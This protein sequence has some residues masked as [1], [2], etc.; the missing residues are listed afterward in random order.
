M[1][2]T[3]DLLCVS[4]HQ[5][6]EFWPYAE[7]L[8]KTA[9]DRC[10]E[11]SVAEIKGQINKGALL[12][13][14]WDGEALKAACVTRL[15]EIKGEKM[16]QVIACAG[17]NEDWRTRFEEIE[18]YA[19]NEGCVKAQIQGRKGWQRIFSDYELAWVTL[20]RRLDS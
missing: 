5:A 13:I 20:E 18:D 17:S 16:L 1:I 2:A 6:D 7:P 19:R 4:P 9:C 8:L 10:G 15:V 3:A 11:W 14:I 12:W